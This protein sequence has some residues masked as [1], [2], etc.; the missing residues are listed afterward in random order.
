MPRSGAFIRST[1]LLVTLASLLVAC[2]EPPKDPVRAGG[3]RTESPEKERDTGPL[4]GPPPVTIHYFDQSSELEAWTF[5]YGNGCADGMPPVD[6]VD[7]GSPAEV[8]V[9]FPLEDWRFSATFEASGQKCPRQQQVDLEPTSGGGFVLRPA[10]Y[11]G[12]YDVTLMGRGD[13]DLFTT[14]RWTTPHDG[15]LP[16]PKA[17]L[18]VLADHDGRVDSYGVELMLTNLE[19]TPEAA[20]ATITVRSESGEEITFDAESAR[21]C[22]SEGTAYWDGPDDKGLEAATLGE[23]PFTYEVELLLDGE[24]YTARATWPDDEIRGNEPSVSLDFEPDLPA[25]SLV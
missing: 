11:A 8:L 13:G 5:C 18:A 7:V 24:R 19:E 23:G 6:L 15:P 21:G 1:I 25:L 17:R 10:G 12:T 3:A 22:W 9:T 14:F 4:E 2:G 20:A 16:K